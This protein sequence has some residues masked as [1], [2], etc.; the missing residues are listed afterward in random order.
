MFSVTKQ[1]APKL[2]VERQ[3]RRHCISEITPDCCLLMTNILAF[4]VALT[5]RIV[6]YLIGLYSFHA[7]RTIGVH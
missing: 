2:I 4:I 3:L 6:G 1:D 7:T 5:H